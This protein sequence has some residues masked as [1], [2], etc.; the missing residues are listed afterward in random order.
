MY[1]CIDRIRASLTPDGSAVAMDH[2][3]LGSLSKVIHPWDT[4]VL[5]LFRTVHRMLYIASYTSNVQV[6]LLPPQQLKQ[7]YFQRPD[8]R[9]QG[10][11][12]S[13]VRGKAS[14]RTE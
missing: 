11:Y 4:R 7:A 9:S 5:S 14:A 8:S 10:I 3:P 12:P 6:E 1:L 2:Y 13:K